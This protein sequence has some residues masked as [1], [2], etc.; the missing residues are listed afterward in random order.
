MPLAFNALD[1]VGSFVGVVVAI[2]IPYFVLY[3]IFRNDSPEPTEDELRE[4]R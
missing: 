3:R 1:A 4:G 2:A